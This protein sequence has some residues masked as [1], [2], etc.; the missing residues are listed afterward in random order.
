MNK[1]YNN[2]KINKASE[3]ASKQTKPLTNEHLCEL[4]SASRKKKCFISLLKSFTFW[5]NQRRL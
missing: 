1:Y 2:K 3:R 5:K 4:K